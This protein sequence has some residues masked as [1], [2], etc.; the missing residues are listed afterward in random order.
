MDLVNHSSMALTLDSDVKKTS[1]NHSI[2]WN[3]QPPDH[4]GSRVLHIRWKLSF[5]R[6]G[7]MDQ[8]VG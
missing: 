5:R 1:L 8:T 7:E 4:S 3:Y 6:F 2:G